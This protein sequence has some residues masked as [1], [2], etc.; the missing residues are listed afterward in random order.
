MQQRRCA[1]RVVLGTALALMT[2]LGSYEASAAARSLHGTDY[3]EDYNSRKNLRTCDRE[4]DSNKTK[5]G[6]SATRNGGEDGSVTDADGAN[7]VCASMGLP[8][9]GPSI[10]KHHTCEKNHLTWNC[11]NWVVV[12]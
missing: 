4:S 10:A 3:S 9:P 6:F 5:G 1:T 11:G 12:V 8:T 7:G 2:A